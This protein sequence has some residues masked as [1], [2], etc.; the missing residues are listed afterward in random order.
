MRTD[1]SALSPKGTGYA[2]AIAWSLRIIANRQ[3][4]AESP[5]DTLRDRTPQIQKLYLPF[6]VF[7]Q[8]PTNFPCHHGGKVI[9][10]TSYDLT[11]VCETKRITAVEGGYKI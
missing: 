1:R 9:N 2:N 11:G 6:T 7:P 4:G 5:W 10:Y 3:V 8:I